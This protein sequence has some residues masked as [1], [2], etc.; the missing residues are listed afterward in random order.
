MVQSRVAIVTG[1]AMGI[2]K[3]ISL[4][5]ARAGHIVVVAD[6]N[7]LEAKNAVDEIK[8][9]SGRGFFIPTDVSNVNS[10]D[11]MT[12]LI[13]EKYGRIDILINNAGILNKTDIL[14][15]EEG[16]WDR[17]MG[18]NLKSVMFASQ[19]V[20]NPMIKARWGRIVNIASIAGRMGGLSAGCAYAASK[21][22]IIGLTM[23]MARKMAGYGI[24]I[25]AIAP[26]PTKSEL[27]KGFNEK[28]I[29]M[30]GES[31]PVGRLGE[32]EDMAKAAAFLV[33][34]GAGFIT[35]AV[36]DVN[37]GMHMGG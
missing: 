6:I 20:L 23:S 13:I 26:G 12:N 25:N 5:L 15:L 10:L 36:L 14:D 7:D 28:E 34:E 18:I 21:A 8:N 16:E 9:L 11:N 30:L 17:V 3:A 27:F 32:P 1:G 2:G 33:S 4:E 22:G 29:K 37:G 19:K 31:I 35:G 24:T